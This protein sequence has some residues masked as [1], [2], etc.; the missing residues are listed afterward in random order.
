M[1]VPELVPV[2]LRDYVPGLLEVPA[3]PYVVVG[4]H[5]GPP[6]RLV[7]QMAGRRRAGVGIHGDIDIIP[8]GVPSRWEIGGADQGLILRVAPG[9]LETV[10]ERPVEIR[11]RF[12]IRDTRIEHIGW[13]MQAEMER[14]FPAGRIYRESLATALAAHLVAAHSGKEQSPA[15]PRWPMPNLKRVLAYIEDNL[16]RDVSL[17]EIAGV[18]GL[19]VSHTK[20]LF[21]RAM[22]LP[23]HQYVI[24]RRVDLAA[25]LLRKGG[26]PVSRAALQAGFSHQSHLARHMR[27]LLGVTPA[28]LAARSGRTLPFDVHI[29]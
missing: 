9:L 2:I 5:L 16:A 17:R 1:S 29:E 20:T 27:R 13:A 15:E 18:A 7:S 11:D 19:S 24:R 26:I 14:G 22:G 23:V 3:L 6:A 28:A 21:R 12:L 4:L 8:V 25:S 10:A